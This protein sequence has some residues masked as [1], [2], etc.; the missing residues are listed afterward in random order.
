[1]SADIRSFFSL[2]QKRTASVS[3]DAESD[4]DVETGG[5]TIEGQSHLPERIN[6]EA[7]SLSDKELSIE[8]LDPD[9]PWPNETDHSQT[10]SQSTSGLST[11]CEAHGQGEAST[12]CLHHL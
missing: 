12:Q 10:C 4:H 7:H 3:V 2:G 11:S 1:M 9:S 8:D 6:V 5:P